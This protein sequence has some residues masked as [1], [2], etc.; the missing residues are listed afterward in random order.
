MVHR[1]ARTRRPLSR[2][3][4]QRFFR[5]VNIPMRGVL[6]LPVATPLGRRLM[7]V[8]LTGRRTGRHYRQPL[9]YVRRGATLLTPGGGNWKL[10]LSDE[11]PVI[12]RLRGRDRLARPELVRDAETV[13]QLLSVMTSA[14]PMV[15]RFVAIPR[16]R[17]GRYDRARLELALQH[18]FCVVR[19]HLL[20]ER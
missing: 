6:G 13:E 17:G 5:V 9:S 3:L 10:N 18:G 14:N 4:Q 11:R 12:I 1:G 8:H 15:G 7:L 20:D 16:D 2:R 19:W